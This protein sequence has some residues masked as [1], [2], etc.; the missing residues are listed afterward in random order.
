MPARPALWGERLGND[1]S[2]PAHVEYGFGQT[3]KGRIAP[4]AEVMKALAQASSFKRRTTSGRR[5]VPPSV[6]RRAGSTPIGTLTY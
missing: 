3:V 6:D 1:L 2:Y 5:H 4:A